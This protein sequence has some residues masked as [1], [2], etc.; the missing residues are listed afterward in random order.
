MGHHRAARPRQRNFFCVCV[1][2]DLFSRYVPGWMLA[3][4]ENAQLARRLIDETVARHDVDPKALTIHSDRGVPAAKPVAQLLATLEITRSVTR[5]R[6]PND[7]PYSE[8]QFRTMKYRPQ[9]PGRFAGIDDA[10]AFSVGFFAMAQLPAPPLR[11]RL[12]HSRQRLPPHR[13]RDPPTPHPSPEPGVRRPP[14]TLRRRPANPNRTPRDRLHQP[15]QE[16][17]QHPPNHQQTCVTKVDRRRGAPRRRS[18]CQSSLPVLQARST[19][20]S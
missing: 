14:R 17:H 12:P 7:N 2:L 11:H 18:T 19:T 15:T 20:V 16:D 10:R 1:L 13:R 6:T 5:P 4:V 9:F 3:T 8:S